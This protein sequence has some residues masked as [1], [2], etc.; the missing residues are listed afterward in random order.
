MYRQQR[1]NSVIT[2]LSKPMGIGL[3]RGRAVMGDIGG[4]TKIEYTAVGDTVDTAVRLQASPLRLIFSR[5]F[6]NPL[7]LSE[8]D[9]FFPMAYKQIVEIPRR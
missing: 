2:S 9:I 6:L 1:P 7:K 4:R 8:V 5:P 3:P